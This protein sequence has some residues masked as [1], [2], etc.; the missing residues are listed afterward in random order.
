[1]SKSTHILLLFKIT[2]FDHT[3]NLPKP[4]T[5]VL[6][7]RRIIVALCLTVTLRDFEIFC[8]LLR[9]K[10]NILDKIWKESDNNET[11]PASFFGDVC[12][13]NGV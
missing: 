13:R 9:E 11:S 2:S 7:D 6:R 1:M 12:K 8:V 3:N 5:A 4:I 10:L